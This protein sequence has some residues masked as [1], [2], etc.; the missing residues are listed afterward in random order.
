MIEGIRRSGCEKLVFR[1][2]DVAHLRQLLQAADP[3][4]PKL[5][6][7]ESLYS[8]DGDVA[9]VGRICEL[10]NAMAR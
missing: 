10:P 6:A 3:R 5:I 8:M 7:F 4:R 1:H 2:N 9:P